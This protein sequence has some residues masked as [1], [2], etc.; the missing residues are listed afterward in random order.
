MIMM[1]KRK[2]TKW[3][4]RGQGPNVGRLAAKWLLL[5][6]LSLPVV[7]T[8]G[9]L[10]L[11]CL[12][13]HHHHI[14]HHHLIFRHHHICRRHHHHYLGYRHHPRLPRQIVVFL[15]NNSCVAFIAVIVLLASSLLSSS[16]HKARNCTKKRKIK[17]LIM[18]S[19]NY[20]EDEFKHSAGCSSIPITPF[21][22][23][24]L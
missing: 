16:S 19:K 7:V 6:A 3:W 23:Q 8:P 15:I 2:D 12:L 9:I 22:K 24:A 11:C 1:K 17:P 14:C 5:A 10:Q 13:L 4:R 20:S 21:N 18:N